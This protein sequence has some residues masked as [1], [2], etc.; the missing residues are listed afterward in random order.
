M[1]AQHKAALAEG[2]SQ[3]RAVRNYLNALEAHKPKRGRRRTPDSI[4]ARLEKIEQE[5]ASADAVKRVDLIQERINL[6]AELE[7]YDSKVDLTDL[8]AEFIEAAAD[9]SARKGISYAAWR[10]AGVPAATLK[11]AGISRSQ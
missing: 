4:S 3:G 10:E 11:A 5:L 6:Q 8:E 7:S 9:Y 1:S 2:R